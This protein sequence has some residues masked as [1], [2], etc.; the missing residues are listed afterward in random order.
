MTLKVW[1]PLFLITLSS[2]IYAQDLAIDTASQTS[3]A[4]LAER[5]RNVEARRHY[6][7]AIRLESEDQYQQAIAELDQ[8][9]ALKY[10]YQD[11]LWLRARLHRH[12]AN[13]KDALTDYQ[14]LLFLVPEQIEARFERAQLLYR[15]ERY[16]DALQDY[17]YLLQNNL[18]E[19]TAVYFRGI[20]Q[21]TSQGTEFIA[22]S[23]ATV[24]SNI[25]TDIW[26]M[27]GLCYLELKNYPKAQLHFELALSQNS[28]DPNIYSNLGLTSEQ[29]GDT[30]AAMNYYRQAL[31]L[32]PD[33]SVA[34]SNFSYL[35]R[36]TKQLDLAEATLLAN[37]KAENSSPYSLLH[38][39]MLL[40]QLGRYH[41]AVEKYSQAIAHSPRDADLFLQRAFS[42]EKL[43]RLEEAL[44]DYSRAIKLNPSLEKAYVNRGNVYYKQQKFQLAIQDY[45]EALTLNTQNA[46]VYYNLGLVYHRLHQ[47]NDACLNL[48]RAEELGY[49]PALR[50]I[51]KVCPKPN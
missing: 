35:T 13:F 31:L 38:S 44:A 20:Q 24:Q 30:L 46:K 10:N 16:E 41:Q 51:N 47:I 9:L 33:H 36:K 25:Q 18:G 3:V 17:I 49:Q 2:T 39:G 19:T 27:M 42:L 37:E 43:R 21:T 12:E 50:I 26:N 29:S 34:L 48:T 7:Q 8:A 32:Q 28:Q 11:A 15:L 6:R 5:S 40:H 23:A 45:N 1:I 4:T 14:S 22:E